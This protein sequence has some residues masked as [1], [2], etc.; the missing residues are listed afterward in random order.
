MLGR[1]L[2]DLECRGESTA[3]GAPKL[4]HVLG[5]VLEKPLLE[6]VG[7]GLDALWWRVL[8]KNIADPGSLRLP[9]ML[10]HNMLSSSILGVTQRKGPRTLSVC[11]RSQLSVVKRL[12]REG[13]LFACRAFGELFDSDSGE[14][15]LLRFPGLG[16]SC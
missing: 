3:H 4:L 5:R 13:E 15:E 1:V 8:V 9:M 12:N 10:I 2:L 7:P 11:G 14:N 16:R 6:L